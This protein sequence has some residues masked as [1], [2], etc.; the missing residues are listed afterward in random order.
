[1]PLAEPLVPGLLLAWPFRRLPVA[2]LLAAVR[3]AVWPVR[4]RT[5]ELLAV[6][7]LPAWLFPQPVAVER[8]AETQRREAGPRAPE[9]GPVAP[10]LETLP[11]AA[12]SLPFRPV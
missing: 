6:A 9:D 12:F 10:C 3:L 11:A 4:R 7:P 2:A 1:M 8:M 5:A